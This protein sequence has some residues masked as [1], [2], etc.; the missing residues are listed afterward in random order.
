MERALTAKADGSIKNRKITTFIICIMMLAY[1]LSI[2]LLGPLVI[3]FIKQYGLSLSDN[4]LITLFQGMGGIIFVFLGIFLT[5]KL[6]KP[7]MIKITFGVYCFSLILLF[8][9]QEYVVLLLL[10]FAIGASTRMLEAVVNAY[11]SDIYQDRRGFYL[12]IV[13]AFF[14]LGALAGPILSSFF[15]D[16]GFQ[17][18][19]IFLTLGVF[20]LAVYAA[21]LYI[22]RKSYCEI[23][24]ERK[25]AGS[26]LKMLRNRNML[27]FFFLAF[28]YV[29]FAVGS[30]TWM[31]AY[32]TTLFD[33]GVSLSGFVVSALWLGITIGRVVFFT[34]PVIPLTVAMAGK[35]LPQNT[36]SASSVVTLGGTTG[37]M[38][39]PWL[40][41]IIADGITFNTAILVLSCLPFLI[42]LLS[43][44]I[45]QERTD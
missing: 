6:Q 38:V 8:F 5:E 3:V 28:I 17:T 26:I 31:P 29:G 9:A 32:I 30:S 33:T 15:V 12:N 23:S 22:Q 11:I 19:L 7:T 18:N 34:G 1:A 4:G 25:S 37:L 24:A 14:G 40:V 44:L 21:Y 27:V 43:I 42:S 20:C 16:N 36:G 35:M 41:G 45:K 10:F 13:H 2:T 39:I